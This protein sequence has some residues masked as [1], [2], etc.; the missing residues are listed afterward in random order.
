VLT[1]AEADEIR[2]G[3]AA[4][5]RVPV[6]LKWCEQLLVDRDERRARERVQRR[7]WPGPLDG[8][9]ACSSASSWRAMKGER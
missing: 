4:G 6:L 2:R 9:I 7:P 8:P 3:L 1:D 5:W